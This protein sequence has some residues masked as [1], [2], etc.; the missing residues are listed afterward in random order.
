MRLTLIAAMDENR[1]IG[2]AGG[3]LPWPRLPRD[4]Q[5]FR[6]Y[7]ADKALLLGRRTYEE[8]TGWFKPGHRPIVVSAAANYQSETDHPVVASVEAGIELARERGDAELVVCGGASIYQQTLTLADELILTIIAARFEACADA[9][10]FPDWV[11][12]GFSES[13]RELF[14]ADAENEHGMMVLGLRRSSQR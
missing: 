6:A 12:E 8:M 7:T 11:E 14:E 1:L 3:G 5:H 10:Y 13:S 9:A 4:Q 2:L